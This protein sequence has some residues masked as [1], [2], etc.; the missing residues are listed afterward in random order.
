MYLDTLFGHLLQ[1]KGRSQ[2]S[3]LIKPLLPT[4]IFAPVD[5][6][7]NIGA[8]YGKETFVA[9]RFSF[10]QKC[11]HLHEAVPQPEVMKVTSSGAKM[12]KDDNEK[13]KGGYKSCSKKQEGL[14]KKT[15]C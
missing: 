14:E 2:L 3:Q 15:K 1:E 13:A 7:I 8:F 10:S 12:W 4:I 11:P 9:L 6:V 5:F